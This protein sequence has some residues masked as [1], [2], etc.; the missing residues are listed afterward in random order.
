MADTNQQVSGS[1]LLSG[2]LFGR[3]MGILLATLNILANL[4]FIGIAPVWSIIAI[5]I[6][7]I[8]LYAIAAHGGEMKKLE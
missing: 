2:N 7:A 5:V 6:N 1:L 4:A 8:A 3:T